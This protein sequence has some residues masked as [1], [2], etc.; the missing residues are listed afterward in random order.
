LVY[1][2]LFFG[3]V[4]VVLF[5]VG[6]L[7]QE[8]GASSLLQGAD[9]SGAS[10]CATQESGAS[11]LLQGAGGLWERACSRL[12]AASCLLHEKGKAQTSSEPS[13]TPSKSTVDR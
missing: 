13:L 3:V 11:S 1:G 12:S 7:F 4:I 5:F 10:S 9:G 2:W 6:S 8:S